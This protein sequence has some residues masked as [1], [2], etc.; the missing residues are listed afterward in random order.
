MFT[1]YLVFLS[2]ALLGCIV[3][4]A[5]LDDML[6][7]SQMVRKGYPVGFP[8]IA[9]G[10]LWGSLFLVTPALYLIG[11][12]EAEWDHWI[13]LAIVLGTILS[14]A[15]HHFVYQRGKL[16]DALAGGGRPISAAGWVH[17]VYFGLTLAFIMLF[18]LRSHPSDTDRIVVSLLLLF[19]VLAANHVPFHF[20]MKRYRF[21]WCTVIYQHESTPFFIILGSFVLIDVAMIVNIV[22]A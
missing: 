21:P 6:L 5:Y 20:I 15:M 18:Y 2:I 9:N 7:P 16:P 10:G 1:N 4:L 19:H 3:F 8:L 14:W 11:A 22:I 17:V 13:I 12:H